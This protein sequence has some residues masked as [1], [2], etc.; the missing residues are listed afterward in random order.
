MTLSSE[1]K[2][3]NAREAARR[4]RSRNPNSRKQYYD[5]NRE[6]EIERSRKWHTTNSEKAREAA[7]K[8][9]LKNP[10][11]HREISREWH[12]ANYAANPEKAKE[13]IRKWK[14][15]NIEKYRN[16]TRKSSRKWHFVHRDLDRIQ[17]EKRRHLSP[18]ET[19]LNERF[20]GSWLHHMGDGFGAYIPASLSRS[21]SHSLTQNRNMTA[22]NLAAIDFVV[23]E[24]DA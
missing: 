18:I 21:I 16:S 12:F 9:R 4:W 13:R 20:P 22:I 5:M 17:S 10:E 11:K 6:K 19:I 15:A 8:W 2:R 3:A 24:L 14:A 7:Q 23:K 1:E